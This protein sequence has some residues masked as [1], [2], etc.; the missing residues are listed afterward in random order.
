MN[1]FET[2]MVKKSHQCS[3]VLVYFREREKKK[4]R[5]RGGVVREIRVG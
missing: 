5:E 4:E 1:E 3:A 2:A